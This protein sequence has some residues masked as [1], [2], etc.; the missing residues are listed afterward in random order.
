M[1]SIFE[2]VD[3]KVCFSKKQFEKKRSFFI[4]TTN[5]KKGY[6]YKEPKEKKVIHINNIFGQKD[7][8]PNSQEMK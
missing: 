5:R 6:P 1:L 7:K 4:K 2:V 3:K 8:Q